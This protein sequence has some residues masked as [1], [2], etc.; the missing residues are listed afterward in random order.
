MNNE[1][2]FDSS[3]D[4]AAQ[5]T[6]NE[7]K[8]G[9]FASREPEVLHIYIVDEPEEL[10]TD[11][12]IVESTIASTSEHGARKHATPP[13]ENEIA[14]E[15]FER[16]QFNLLPQL[17]W[18]GTGLCIVLAVIN[19]VLYLPPLFGASSVTVTL[20]PVERL[21]SV[22]MTVFLSTSGVTH[23]ALGA[24]SG[25]T[26]STLTLTQA[27]TVPTTG[28]G[29]ELAKPGRGYITFYNSAPYVQSIPSGTLL[30]GRNGT[31]VVT[32]EEAVIPAAAYPAFGQ[33]TI[34]AHTAFTGPAG[35]ISAKDI[36]GPC[37]QLNVSSVNSTFIGGQN[38]RTFPIVTSQ[39]VATG[40]AL[41]RPG[42]L[43][44]VQAAL[45]TELAANETQIVPVPC[46]EDVK[47]SSGINEEATSVTVQISEMCTGIAYDTATL[48]SLVTEQLARQARHELG[49]NYALVGTVTIN[50]LRASTQTKTGMM[51]LTI[52][53]AG[54]WA[55]QFSEG[56]LQQMVASIAGKNET[57]AT[58]LLLHM[59]GVSQVEMSEVDM[60]LPPDATH[61]HVLVVE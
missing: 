34:A 12:Q 9:A 26:L 40:E 8:S 6:L 46:H 10:Q 38:A 43:A 57:Q 55:Y 15:S 37:C 20:I 53:S 39:D 52:K 22:T 33:A 19:G 11:G 27:T 42:L 25:R 61:I 7:K 29:H 17:L 35:N 31:E 58:S 1:G 44:S 28:T 45:K 21:T 3:D 47:S 56:E 24:L 18:L 2:V 51:L 59:P 23:P 48:T 14:A 36:Y 16:E 30:T 4:I 60:T 54:K 13:L 49:M 5:A 41:L 50:I 32:D